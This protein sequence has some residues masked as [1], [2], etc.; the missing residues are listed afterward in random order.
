MAY[1]D[2]QSASK[3]ATSLITVGAIHAVIGAT[4]IYGLAPGLVDVIN[5]TP[6]PNT[7]DVKPTEVPPPETA[8]TEQRVESVITAPPIP[9]DLVPARPLEPIQPV[10]VG[11]A[12]ETGTTAQPT[13]GVEERIVPATPTPAFTATKPRPI[14]DRGSW[15]TAAD[16]PGSDL[17]RGNEGATQFRVVVGSNGRVQACETVVSSGFAGLD[18]ATCARVTSRARFEPAIN[19]SGEQVVGTYTGTVR[20]Q[21]PE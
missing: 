12:T 8:K 4:L 14:N 3:R 6:P 13:G 7:F 19:S 16:Y 10:D 18:K 15:V 5:P 20:W 2:R 17:R 1:V 21:I 9:M 11:P